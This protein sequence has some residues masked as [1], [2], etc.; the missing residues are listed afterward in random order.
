[1]STLCQTASNP[2]NANLASKSYDLS[3]KILDN[4][5]KNTGAKNRGV[6]KTDTMSGINWAKVPTTIIEMGFLSNPEED[7]KLSTEDYQQKIVKGIANGID[8]YIN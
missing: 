2:Y 3:K 1:M 6:T 5:V 4:M 7:K 8:E